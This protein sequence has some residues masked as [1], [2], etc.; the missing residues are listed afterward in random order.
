[1]AGILPVGIC[2]L[3]IPVSLAKPESFEEF[4]EPVRTFIEENLSWIIPLAVILFALVVVISVICL[5]ISSRGKFMFLDNVVHNRALVKAPWKEYSAVGNSLFWWRLVFLLIM[6]LLLVGIIGGSA[7]YLISTFDQDNLSVAWISV[8]TIGILALMAISLMAIY[9]SILLEDFVIPMMYRDGLS[10]TTA[11]RRFLA[12]HNSHPGRFVLYFFWKA[13]LGIASAMI[14]VMAILITCCFAL[15]ILIIPYL[16]AV[17]LLPVT[18]FSVDLGP[19]F[20]RQFGE[21]YD[22]WHD[23]E[24]DYGFGP[25][26]LP[27]AEA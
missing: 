19:E 12:L 23:S 1:M 6:S 18:V 14:V 20:L 9:I 16:G 7:V 3:E 10:S 24:D 11:W 5:W 27:D 13:V 15:I 21:E 8:L 2:R 17:L 4:I 25:P 22:L 26:S